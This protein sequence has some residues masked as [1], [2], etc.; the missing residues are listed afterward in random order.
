VAEVSKVAKPTKSLTKVLGQSEHVKGLVEEA[1]EELSSIN[2]VLKQELEEQEPLPGVEDALE[3]SEA[4]EEKVN[5]ASEKLAVVNQ[6]L[7]DEVK[8]RSV[9]E[10]QLAATARQGVADRH[11]SLHDP[12]TGLPN[13]ALFNDRLE[14]GMAQAKRHGWA[15]AVMF[16]DLDG[17]KAINDMYGHETGDSVLLQISERLREN[18]RSDDTV[19]RHGGDEF[20]YLLMEVGDAPDIVTVAEKLLKAI[21]APCDIGMRQ[22]PVSPSVSASIGIA[23][24]PKNGSNAAALVKSA[25]LAMYEAKRGG[26]RYAF[27]K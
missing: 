18:T 1:A 10:E 23:V 27:A 14:H 12:L 13:R 21:Q 22:P 3:K 15:L 5:D 8:D 9:L 26:T 2:E 19:F 24:Y 25:D 17:F 16:L 11:A 20:L 7:E 4:V 6:A